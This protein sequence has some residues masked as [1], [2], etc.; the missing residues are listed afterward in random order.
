MSKETQHIECKLNFNEDVIETLV[1]FANAKGGR[2]FVGVDDNGKP[3]K[4]F[5]IGKESV[6]NW[7]NEIKNKTQ[8]QII[9]DVLVEQYEGINVAVF[10]VQEY[11]IKPVS[12]RGKYYKRVKNSNHLLSVSEVVNLHLQ[13]LNTSW[14]AYPDQ[15]H[16]LDDISLDKVQQSIEILRAKGQTINESPLSFLLKSDLLRDDKPTNAAYLLFKANNTSIGTTIEL[17]RFQDIITIKDTSR[18]KSDILTQVNEVLDFVKK[19]INLEIIITSEAQNIQKW[20][21]PLEAIREI[22]LN[23]II[24]RDYCAVADSVVKI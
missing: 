5:K 12:C 15:L 7:I 10:E 24:H 14:D 18:T 20:Q 8:P 6:Q 21:Y 16:G 3:N 9:P 1:A 13:A 2:V 4:N 23:M 19:H 11:P 17:G 22:V